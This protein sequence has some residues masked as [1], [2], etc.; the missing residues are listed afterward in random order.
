MSSRPDFSDDYETRRSFLNQ[1]ASYIQETRPDSLNDAAF[2]EELCLLLVRVL[3]DNHPAI[4][5]MCFHLLRLCLFTEKN[6]ICILT[7]QADV[8]AV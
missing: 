8:Y 3:R 4:R 1:L 2:F 7:S 5:A 6:L